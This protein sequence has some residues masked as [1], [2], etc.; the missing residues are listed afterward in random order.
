MLNTVIKILKKNDI[1]RI[2]EVGS[3]ARK[4]KNPNDYDLIIMPSLKNKEIWCRI[5]KILSKCKYDGKQVDAQ[6]VPQFNLVLENRW[7][8]FLFDKY[9]FYDGELKHKSATMINDK[10]KKIGWNFNMPLIYK[11]L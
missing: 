1:G 11:E 4:E 10:N 6:I 8:H 3:Y 9:T 5:L 7:Q 2:F